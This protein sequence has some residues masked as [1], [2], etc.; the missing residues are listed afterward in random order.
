[1]GFL[2]ESHIFTKNLFVLCC[3]LDIHISIICHLNFHYQTNLFWFKKLYPG[4][5]SHLKI[6]VSLRAQHK[7]WISFLLEWGYVFAHSLKWSFVFMGFILDILYT[8]VKILY[9]FFKSMPL[10]FWRLSRRTKL[11]LIEMLVAWIRNRTM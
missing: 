1:M 7:F 6:I 4:L 5:M 9:L 11:G 2:F 3:F 8:V 10:Y